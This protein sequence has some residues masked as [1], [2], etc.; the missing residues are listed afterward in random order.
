MSY[1]RVGAEWVSGRNDNAEGDKSEVNDRYVDGGWGED[2]GGLAFGKRVLGFE[3][4]RE[5]VDLAEQTRV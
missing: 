3:R 1:L 5:G 2:K 4:V